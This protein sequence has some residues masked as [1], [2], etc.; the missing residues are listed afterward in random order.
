MK[1]SFL[2]ILVLGGCL[3]CNAQSNEKPLKSEKPLAAEEKTDSTFKQ[4]HVN[5]DVNKQY[6]D[7]GNLIGYDSTYTYVYQSFDGD[8]VHLNMDS[9]FNNFQPLFQQ[10]FDFYSN[11]LMQGFFEKD[12]LFYHDFF[13]D[14][15]FQKRFRMQSRDFEEMF[16]KMD[17][18]KNRL[19]QEKLQQEGGSML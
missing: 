6:D 1:I 17:S 14:S 10:N 11:N 18:L 5:I 3:S 12:S 2:T 9:V 15:F 7:E 13:N 16:R 19:Y 8:S 4:P